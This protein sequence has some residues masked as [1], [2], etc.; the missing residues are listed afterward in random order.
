MFEPISHYEKLDDE[1]LMRRHALYR[2]S[3]DIEEFERKNL[4]YVRSEYSSHATSIGFNAFLDEWHNIALI[5]CVIGNRGLGY[6]PIVIGRK[7]A[8]MR[9]TEHYTSKIM[10]GAYLVDE[11][12]EDERQNLAGRRVIRFFGQC[13]INL[14]G[15]PL[16]RKVLMEHLSHSRM[17]EEEWFGL[18]DGRDMVRP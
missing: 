16:G 11:A 8:M 12:G 1:T 9:A 10:S 18:T 5:E 3:N 17:I 13:L 2:A 7:T 4:E 14:G 6:E 15:V